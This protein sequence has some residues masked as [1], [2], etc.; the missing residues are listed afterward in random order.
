MTKLPATVPT[1]ASAPTTPTATHEPDVVHAIV[2]LGEGLLTENE[3]TAETGV[4][5][6]NLPALLAQPDMLAAVQRK[7]V[8]LL[9]NGTLARLEA[10]RHSPE[11][12][13][14]AA[15]IMQDSEMNASNRLTAATFIAK[16]SGT[17]RPAEDGTK[18]K[19]QFRLVIN[20]GGREP[21]VI[22]ANNPQN[23]SEI[24]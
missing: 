6:M 5:S 16:A 10:A 22:T 8:E 21:L 18:T 4:D 12:V 3:F 19:D 9:N 1:T 23:G 2:L 20:L 15:Q 17:E 11:A 14:V 13:R 24:V 7:R